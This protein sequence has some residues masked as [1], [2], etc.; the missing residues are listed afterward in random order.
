MDAAATIVS[1]TTMPITDVVSSARAS[2]AGSTDSNW[3]W[4]GWMLSSEI[5][6]STGKSTQLRPVRVSPRLAVPPTNTCDASVRAAITHA[7]TARASPSNP[8]TVLTTACPP[9]NCLR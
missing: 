5:P 2:R 9:L 8:N 4:R 1:G 3:K 6:D 7:R